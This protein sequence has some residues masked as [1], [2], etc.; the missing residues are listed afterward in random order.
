MM[1]T[2]SLCDAAILNDIHLGHHLTTTEHVLRSLR[3][4]LPDDKE[5]KDLDVIWLAGD[6]FDRLL[7]YADECVF[8][9]NEW[10]HDLLRLCKTHDILLRIL[11]GTPSHDNRQSRWF[12]E[13]NETSGIGADVAYFDTVTIEYMERFGIHVL[14]VP[15]EYSA[16]CEITKSIVQEKMDELNLT[17]VDFAI[18]H[19]CFPHQMPSGIDSRQLHDPEFYVSIVKEFIFIGHIHVKSQ[20]KTIYAG[21]SLDRDKHDQE[22]PKGHLRYRKRKGV[23]T[24]FFRENKNAKKYITVNL[25]G[26][27]ESEAKEKLDELMTVMTAGDHLRIKLKKKDTNISVV[28][29]FASRYPTIRWSYT[30]LAVEE[31]EDLM[32]D[33]RNVITVTPIHR[34]NIASLLLD[35]VAAK[36][37][38]LFDTATALLTEVLDE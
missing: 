21:G 9:I 5:T 10:I 26:L 16:T 18:M 36:R 22:Q 38:E 32:V 28:S 34:A 33:E 27:T 1:M 19:G 23:G 14:Y 12:I 7:T 11:E 29:S 24:V 15:D 13:L 2:L 25:K 35:R 37:P 4:A 30:E 8:D 6:I 3:L 17:Q 31:T 20:Y